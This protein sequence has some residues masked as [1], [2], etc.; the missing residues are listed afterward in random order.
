M[1][2]AQKLRSEAHFAR[3]A[4]KSD[5]ALSDAK[6]QRNAADGLFTRPL[7]LAFARD[8]FNLFPLTA[9]RYRLTI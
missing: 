3:C 8:A 1:Q 4:A 9:H 5:Q 6:L 2:G 7:E